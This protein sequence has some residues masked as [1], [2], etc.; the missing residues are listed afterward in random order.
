MDMDVLGSHIST[1]LIHY[2]EG[3]ILCALIQNKPLGFSEEEQVV[4]ML[5]DLV[6]QRW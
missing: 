6:S 2:F 1:S 5:I 4:E 3:N